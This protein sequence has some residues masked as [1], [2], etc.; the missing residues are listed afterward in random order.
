MTLAF[1]GCRP[2]GGSASSDAGPTVKARPEAPRAR[3]VMTVTTD[4]EE[5]RAL[6]LESRR[7]V[8]DNRESEALEG[9]R[10]AVAKDPDF[11]LALAY[12]GQY[13]P[14]GEGVEAMK[15]A[16]AAAQ[17]LPP[18]ERAFIELL[19]AYR[20]GDAAQVSRATRELLKAAPDEWRA[21]FHLGNQAY[22]QRNWPLAIAAYRKSMELADQTPTCQGYNNLG[23]AQAMGGHLEL[24]LA[25]LKRC[26]D[27]QP[28]EPNPH[29]SVGEVLLAAGRFDESE[30]AFRRALSKDAKFFYAWEGLA[31]VRLF[32]RDATGA[33]AALT[34]A[35]EVA[36]AGEERGEV[37]VLAAWSHFAL[38]NEPQKPLQIL[39]RMEA[40]A[41]RLKSAGLYDVADALLNRAGIL[42]EA[43]R[44]EE[45]LATSEAALTASSTRGLP[46]G[47][48][49]A[50]TRRAQLKKLRALA[51]LGRA[52]EAKPLLT[53]LELS[54]RGQTAVAEITSSLHFA[55]GVLAR[56]EGDRQAAERELRRCALFGL[57]ERTH[58]GTVKVEDPLCLLELIDVRRALGDEA[59]A[60]KTR[61]LLAKTYH[62]DPIAMYAWTRVTGPPR[63]AR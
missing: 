4:S 27:L 52:D 38:T 22:E 55:R 41:R 15:R 48:R 13:A 30:E 51:A 34:K 16:V 35:R 53:A 25:A 18:A 42:L 11:A 17:S 28:E 8:E 62:R 37:D 54:H 32:Q 47:L 57:T 43:E 46:E 2:P 39:A 7:R 19:D 56:A 44:P 1:A 36:P 29:D 63:A 31:A 45:A 58:D 10:Q 12:I 61:A 59:G 3:Q 40:E 24:A 49:S 21:S 33:A 23:Y 26:T 9:F 6:F 20:L 14:G 50:L 5:A 60:E